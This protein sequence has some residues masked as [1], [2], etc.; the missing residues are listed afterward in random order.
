MIGIPDGF[1]HLE[2]TRPTLILDRERALRN[3]DRM[4]RKANANGVTLRPHFK[5]HQ[6]AEIGRWFRDYGVDSIT[7]SSLQ[8]AQYFAH[9]GW[10]DITV[11]FPVNLRE[12]SI[13]N[14]LADH[15]RLGVLLDS[16]RVIEGLESSLSGPVRV[17][18]KVDCGYGRVGVPWNDHERIVS[19]ARSIAAARMKFAGILTH[20]GQSYHETSKEGVRRVYSATLARMLGAKEALETAG[21]ADCAI[22]IGDTPTCSVVDD[23]SHVDEIRPGNFV[24]YDVMQHAIGSC[25]D[26]EMAVAV[27]C[28]VVGKY[29]ERGE[30][31][32]YGGAAH[33]S[34]EFLT[35]ESG[36]R[37]FGYLAR[38]GED[39]IGHLESSAPVVS[40]SQEHGT[41]QLTPALMD[42]IEIADV[43]LVLPVHSCL[44]CNLHTDYRTLEGEVVR[45]M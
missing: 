18:I 7:V 34:K 27:A 10:S 29:Q 11:A 36:R 45:R 43:V 21:L 13:I 3:I 44:T 31:V 32:I 14:E 37:V 26:E 17:W 6:S 28:P 4:A 23:L 20:S 2:I 5:T 9:D 38:I 19:M 40:L 1:T 35:S 33:L 16:E 42:E 24:F 22:S 8:M 25:S 12:V 15:V 41:V 39:L 30:I